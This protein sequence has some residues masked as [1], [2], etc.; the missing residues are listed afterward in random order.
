MATLDRSIRRLDNATLGDRATAALLEFIQMQNL[1]PGSGLPS[2]ARLT[3]FLGVS[4]PVVREAL[5]N[6]RGLGV[7]EILNGRGA[8]VRELNASS[9]EVFFSHA[10][11]TVS[12]SLVGLMEL[13]TGLECEAAALAAKRHTDEDARIMR[14]LVERMAKST[15]DARAYSELD[16]KLHVAIS[17]A[18]GNMLYLHMVQSIRAAMR[19]ASRKGMTLRIGNSETGVVQKMHEDIVAAIIR[20]DADTA[21]AEMRRHMRAATDLF[22][23]QQ[24]L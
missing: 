8:V 1:Q 2:E 7:V 22:E 21:F 16:V 24:Q 12:N 20:R 14:D 6:L 17:A 3:E 5:R 15:G 23:R 10:L 19:E 9:L 4:R 11:Q 18:S 13:R